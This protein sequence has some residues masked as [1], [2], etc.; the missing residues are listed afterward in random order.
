[1][2][3]RDARVRACMDGYKVATERGT[4]PRARLPGVSGG[5]VAPSGPI[6]WTGRGCPR[7]VA[8]PLQWKATSSIGK[9][10]SAKAEPRSSR[11]HHREESS[12]RPRGTPSSQSSLSPRFP[13]APCS[14][15]RPLPCWLCAL[16][17]SSPQKSMYVSHVVSPC[18]AMRK[19]DLRLHP[20]PQARGSQPR[21]Y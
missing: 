12:I 4:E 7:Q 5:P 8:Q 13:L 20:V 19:R 3:R 21:S 14:S 6:I 15:S 10:F 1:M 17:L 16:L 18:D 2:L 9:L 11:H